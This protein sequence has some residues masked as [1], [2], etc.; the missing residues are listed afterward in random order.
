GATAIFRTMALAS[1]LNAMIEVM[2]SFGGRRLTPEFQ[3]L[4]FRG[5]VSRFMVHP[6]LLAGFL[7]VECGASAGAFRHRAFTFK[8]RLSEIAQ[9]TFIAT[10]ESVCCR[11]RGGLWRCADLHLCFNPGF[12][13]E[14]TK[15]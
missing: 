11:G 4:S 15:P 8:R 10:R 7:A 9:G 6:I 12:F 14:K 13:G 1:A 5:Q 2:P 3:P